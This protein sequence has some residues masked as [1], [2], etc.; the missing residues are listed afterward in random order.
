MGFV[1]IKGTF[2]PGAGIPDGDTTRFVPNNSAHLSRL[3]GRKA[4]VSAAGSVSLRL[5]GIDA[6]EKAAVKP[7]SSL[8]T[9]ALL[10]AIGS[11]AA[12]RQ[13]APGW[14]LARTTESNGRVVAFAFAGATNR[15]D[16]AD[17]FLD[18]ALLQ[19][20]V[21]FSQVQNGWAYPLYYNTLFGD[22]RQVFA[23]GVTAARLAKV[24]YWPADATLTS[25][26]VNGKADLATIPP[27][28]P[29]L[30]RRLEGY[31]KQTPAPSDLSGFRSYLGKTKER[32]DILTPP[33]TQKS[34]DDIV[35]V[36][37]NSVRLMVDP[38]DVRV[39]SSV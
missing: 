7:A 2:T 21:N 11:S 12:H 15:V 10:V 27:V 32:V 4:K 30:W 28:W 25:V 24:G 8:A 18:G 31:Y 33:V 26:T 34:I 13:N 39:V 38:N 22:L 16:G 3:T 14:I 19:K 5:E 29:K 9:D 36:N 37:G 20:S 35:S 6:I 1:L 17:V 23:D